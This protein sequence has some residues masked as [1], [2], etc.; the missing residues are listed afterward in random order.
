MDGILHNSS[1]ITVNQDL[2]G[3]SLKLECSSNECM[4][5]ARLEWLDGRIPIR[6]SLAN[7]VLERNGSTV[8]INI[9]NFTADNYGQYSCRCV[10]EYSNPTIVPSTW[11]AA[12]PEPIPQINNR[13]SSD[14][15]CNNLEY[16]VHLLPENQSSAEIIQ[17]HYVH[18][19]DNVVE[20]LSCSSGHW[21]VW[22]AYSAPK[23]VYQELYNI[24]VTTSRDQA[25]LICIDSNEKSVQMIYYISIEGYSQ[26]PIG[27]NRPFTSG[28]EIAVD[29]AS[30]NWPLICISQPYLPS[31][32]SITISVN[33][34][35]YGINGDVGGAK[36]DYESH[37]E[38]SLHWV[39]FAIFPP[40]APILR[41]LFQ[42]SNIS[43]KVS[44]YWESDVTVDFKIIHPS[45]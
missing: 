7:L 44:S 20:N 5:D 4:T 12:L 11:H 25:K 38:P 21:R 3:E 8:S 28:D 23:S 27:F 1:N 39:Y 22:S 26:F 40:L 29:E 45:K 17:E 41:Q 42:N 43:C 19:N 37:E 2:I 9:Q 33:S 35:E 24:T 30:E 10:K 6:Q 15:F 16:I 14:P 34:I 32:L 18:K 13:I 36:V 31:D